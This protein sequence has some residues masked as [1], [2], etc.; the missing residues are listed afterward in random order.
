MQHELSSAAATGLAL[1]MGNPKTIAFYLALLPLVLDLS[2]ITVVSWAGAL[3]PLTVLVL[4]AV[5]SIFILGAIVIRQI[6]S[7][8]EAQKYLHRGAA[9]AMAGAASTMIFR[10]I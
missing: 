3:V 6:L 2:N 8:P 10:E 1:T 5:G 9:L 7:K 4:L